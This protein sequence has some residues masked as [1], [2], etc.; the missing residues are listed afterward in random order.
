MFLLDDLTVGEAEVGQLVA[1]LAGA[2]VIVAS[3]RPVLGRHGTSVNLAGLRDTA[4]E[5]LVAGDLGR[6]L[7]AAEK[8]AVR[9]LAQAV[10]GQPLHL[11]QAAALAREDGRPLEELATRAARDPQVLDRLSVDALAEQDRRV[12]AV[13]ALAGGALLPRE[14]IA[15][16]GDVATI[17]ASLGLLRQRGLVEHEQDQFGL[18][19]C[20]VDG[21]RELL[22]QYLQLGGA[23]GTL[24]DWL[25]A[26][27]PTSDEARSAIGGAVNAIGYAAEHGQLPAVVRLVKVLEPILTLAGRWEAARDVLEQGLA[28]ARQLGDQPAEAWFSHQLGTLEV[29]LDELAQGQAHLEEALR[30]RERLQDRAGAALSRHNLEV[31]APPPLPYDPDGVATRPPFRERLRGLL[32]R[33]PVLAGRAAVFGLT[34]LLGLIF[35]PRGA[36]QPPSPA[37][38]PARPRRPPRPRRPR[39]P[40]R[41][42][43]PRPRPARDRAATCPHPH[44]RR[45]RHRRRPRPRPTAHRRS[46]GCRPTWSRRP[47]P[48]SARGCGSPPRRPTTSTES[49]RWPAPRARAPPSRSAPP[50]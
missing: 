21:Y 16:V 22:L 43:R 41:S 9:A 26:R 46:S 48:A 37:S 32:G 18:P 4:A 50:W 17:G 33:W 38:P 34:F 15:A 30:L 24:S 28:A 8:T 39:R 12:L 19:V 36:T 7:T 6:P 44:R 35:L 25:L 5:D 10:G 40:P 13:L 31:L 47:P 11:H 3:T 14:L 27:D 29:S 20:H 1:N 23:L 2:T 49:Y 42:R 45:H